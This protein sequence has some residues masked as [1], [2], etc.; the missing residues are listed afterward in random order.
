MLN[1]IVIAE[2]GSVHDGSFGNARKLIALAAK[3]GANV[4]KFQ[5]HIASAETIRN[6]PSPSYFSDEPRYEYFER[7]SFTERD[8]KL[9]L[10]ECSQKNIQFLSSPFS[11]AAVDLLARIGSEMYKIPSGEVTNIPLLE[12]IAELGKPV[13]LSSGMS[14]WFELD[15]AVDVFRGKVDLCVMQC[16]S[17]YPC[18]LDRVGLNIFQEL[19]E[20]YGEGIKIGF[21]DHSSGFAAGPAAAALGATVIE[22]HLTF[23]K[24]M[25]GSDA[26]NALEPRDFSLY[27]NLIHDVWE[28]QAN[29]VDKDDNTQLKD[30]KRIFEKSV[31][32]SRAIPAKTIIS[33]EDLD[34]KKPG[35]GISAADY[36]LVIGRETKIGLPI[37]HVFSLEDFE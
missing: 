20:R 14:S 27:T 21:S 18:A 9:L 30:M 6:A 25:F 11:N 36:M 15:R 5:T 34:Y 31:V 32:S 8:W 3:C 16:T 12:K 26:A 4:V 2:I 33:Q 23:S 35:N 37:D 13:L 17:A 29:P 1:K 19:R 7:T 22:K 28:M 10:E 24:A